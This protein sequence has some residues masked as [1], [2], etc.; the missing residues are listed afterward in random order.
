MFSLK[1]FTK[2]QDLGSFYKI[3]GPRI[4]FLKDSPKNQG[5]GYF[6]QRAPKKK[7]GLNTAIF[8]K[9]TF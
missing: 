9:N 6:L 3:S 8:L 7:A 2:F 4:L 5:F 1:E